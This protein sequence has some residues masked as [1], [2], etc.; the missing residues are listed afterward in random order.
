MWVHPPRNCLPREREDCWLLPKRQAGLRLRTPAAMWPGLTSPSI[1]PA[2][3]PGLGLG[4]ATP[5]MAPPHT[6]PKE[7]RAW[8]SSHPE[9]VFRGSVKTGLLPRRQAGLRLG[10]PAAMWP[11][12]TYPSVSPDLFQARAWV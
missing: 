3:L 7:G 12:L 11:G 5:L 2:P 8:G 1:S 10:T 9:T 4:L 6:K